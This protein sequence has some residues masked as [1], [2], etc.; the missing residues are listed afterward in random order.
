MKIN[1]VIG[2]L[3]IGTFISCSPKTPS[4]TSNAIKTTGM[5]GPNDFKNMDWELFDTNSTITKT[6]IG[7]SNLQGLW[8][9]YQ[10]AFRLGDNVNTMNLTQPFVIEFK[11]GTYRR[12][13]TDKFH[14]FTIKNN[15]IICFDNDEKDKGFIN[16]ITPNDL[17]ISWKNGSNY[18]RY[19]YKK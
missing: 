11:D 8:K 9:A 18:N 13:L 3:I 10:G 6:G 12:S 16:Q 17:T 14:P 7:E 5:L 1:I 19:Y 2:F 15:I 4:T